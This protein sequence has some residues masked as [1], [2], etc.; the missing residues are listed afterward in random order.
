MEKYSWKA[1]PCNAMVT[2][3][4]SSVLED[5]DNVTPR[6]LFSV[7]KYDYRARPARMETENLL[8]GY[9]VEDMEHDFQGRV[10]KRHVLHHASL[11]TNDL[12]EE[13]SY[14]YD[15]AGRLL[16]VGHTV[17][18]GKT[19]VLADNQYDE[20]GRLKANKANGSEALFTSYD[21]NLRSWL[22]KVTNPAFEEEQLYNESDGTAKPLYGGNISSM[23]WKAG[24]DGG[25]RR[26]GF[27]YD[28]LGRLTAATY[29]ENVS[30]G[31]KTGKGGGNYDTRYAYDKMGNIQSLR[32]QGLHDDGV[33][34]VIDD[35]KYTY[36]G[37]Q[38]IR[39]GDSAIDPV[40][41]D[42]FTFVDGADDDTEYEYDENGNLTK[43][44]N[45]G[46]CG[47]EY[48]CLNLPSRVDFADGSRITYTYD[49][50]G[51]KLRTD[52]YMNPL[53]VSVPQL[54]GGAGTAG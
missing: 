35:L 25:S 37:N 52:H 14:A 31:K 1:M 23:E 16:T 30:S 36:D 38:V 49:G 9:D 27:T 40:Y 53:T 7:I 54:A 44:L 20:L 46:I 51:R 33:C 13:Y 26:Y 19:R 32:R 4:V 45:R 47:I 15:H 42:C 18:G 28:G 6:T 5:A 34:D 41:K 8:G 21:Y 12:E 2:G 48:N 22:T 11:L 3:R 50:G 10:T 24:I 39:V 29:D 43:D 17:N